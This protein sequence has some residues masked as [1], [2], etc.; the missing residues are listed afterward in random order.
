MRR[1]DAFE[2]CGR[3]LET[4][5][6]DQLLDAVGDVEV[7]ICVLVAD[8][9]GL[10]VPVVCES[11]A[12]AF[13]VVVVAL[14]DIGALDPELS[15]LARGDFLVVRADVFGRLVGEKSADGAD[16]VVPALP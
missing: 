14:E 2:L 9:A 10:E 15:D 12:S 16:G 8:V 1:E 11:I 5:V 4:L 13:R 7:A 6:L 3:D